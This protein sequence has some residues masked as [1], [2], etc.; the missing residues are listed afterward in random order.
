MIGPNVS[1]LMM[2]TNNS[3]V[4]RLHRRSDMV[5]LSTR[6]GDLAAAEYKIIACCYSRV[7]VSSCVSLSMTPPPPP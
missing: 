5:L 3:H 2:G 6:M 4:W 7:C 1:V